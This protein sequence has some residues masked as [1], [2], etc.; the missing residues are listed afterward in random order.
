[1]DKKRE[2]NA[3]K[4]ARQN[5]RNGK[6]RSAGKSAGE[7]R[8]PAVMITGFF[9]ILIT[10]IYPLYYHNNYI[11]IQDS[12]L[13]FFRIWTALLAGGI[14]LAGIV[15]RL[16]GKKQAGNF[17]EAIRSK[18]FR[19]EKILTLLFASDV[20]ISAL[21]SADPQEALLGTTGRKMGAVVYLLCI[22]A[23]VCVSLYL[24]MGNLL[25]WV[26][27]IANIIT[28]SLGILNLFGIDF[29]HMYDNLLESQHGVF[30]GTIGNSNMTAGYLCLVLP[31]GMTL[32]YLC[33]NLI[34]KI[35]YGLF[36]F[37]G[38]FECYATASD[39][40]VLGCGLAFMALL[41][42]SMT[43]HER[44]L[45]FLRVCGI[46]LLAS[47]FV[48]VTTDIAKQFISTPLLDNISSDNIQTF[49]TGNVFLF[50]MG[51]LIVIVLILLRYCIREGKEINYSLLRKGLFGI[52]AIAFLV[53]FVAFA[54][55]NYSEAKEWTG[56]FAWLNRLKLTN[57]FGTNRGYIWKRT[58]AS[59]KKLP[60]WEKIF[61]Y[62]PNLFQTFIEADYGTEIQQWY[63]RAFID[64]HNEFLQF[65][66]TTGIA[67]V[68][69]YFGLMFACL[70]GCLRKAK[71]SPILIM[72]V[73]TIVSYLGQGLVNNPQIFT[74]P[75]L[76]LFMGAMNSLRRK[77]NVL[78][79]G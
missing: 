4:D 57:S 47:F 67:G 3:G 61:G 25:T 69:G 36:L 71:E 52:M 13:W 27:V 72:G 6:G 76:F 63:G 12:K 41:W 65:L 32:Y 7:K 30:L 31:A 79:A 23:Y 74:T 66:S 29:L 24:E 35:L 5:L 43:G 11:D 64:A 62:G 10:G 56:A 33:E 8:H 16:R 55:A 15:F 51:L 68:V 38:F 77:Q 45:R 58:W 39:S 9:M 37:L 49:F 26:F 48:R 73:I 78:L 40:W 34:S 21:L 53:I 59:W 20:I 44:M 70:T 2:K 22:A 42:F 54:V 17:M 14:I 75:G 60:F 28:F 50:G 46:F 1:M 19:T 18:E